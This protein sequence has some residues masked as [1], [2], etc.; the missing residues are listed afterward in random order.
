M[1]GASRT[2]GSSPATP[3]R[4]GEVFSFACR[5]LPAA[6]A[7][8]F[9]S[10]SASARFSVPFLSYD[11]PSATY[12]HIGEISPCG[13]YVIGWRCCVHTRVACH[14]SQSVPSH[15][16]HG[17]TVITMTLFELFNTQTTPNRT[18]L[19]IYGGGRFPPPGAVF[20]DRGFIKRRVALIQ[21]LFCGP[22][23]HTICDE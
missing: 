8:V 12:R 16:A 17:D 13:V 21:Y 14:N 3:G 7:P 23:R 5:L 18:K 1:P 22:L 4:S 19:R 20:N 11:D 15:H 10:Y 2:S 9:C 6:H